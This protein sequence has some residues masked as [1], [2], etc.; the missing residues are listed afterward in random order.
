MGDIWENILVL[1]RT[2][3]AVFCIFCNLY[4]CFLVVLEYKLL[5]L[6]NNNLNLFPYPYVFCFLILAY[7]PLKGKLRYFKNN[8]KIKTLS[9]SSSSGS[10]QPRL[11]QGSVGL[12]PIKQ[13]WN[14]SH[15]PKSP[16]VSISQMD[17]SWGG[18][19]G[20]ISM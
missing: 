15:T 9:L 5:Q 3:A 4:N 6:S 8:S 17:C 7:I 16:T 2:Q 10:N 19:H 13:P 11:I 1:V 14:W 18:R 12:P 20:N